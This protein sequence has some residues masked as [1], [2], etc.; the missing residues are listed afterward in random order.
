MVDNGLS[1]DEEG[2]KNGAE[3]VAQQMIKSKDVSAICLVFTLFRERTKTK[4]SWTSKSELSTSCRSTSKRSTTKRNLPSR[5]SSSVASLKP[6][7]LPTGTQTRLCLTAS[8]L[9]YLRWRNKGRKRMK[10][11]NRAKMICTNV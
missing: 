5:S 3:A 7:Q 4:K 1:S 9:F 8:S 10:K 6:C 2:N 11:A